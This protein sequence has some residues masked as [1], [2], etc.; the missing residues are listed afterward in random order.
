MLE[1]KDIEITTQSGETRNYVISKFPAIAGREIIAKYP[2][3]AI[4]RLGDYDVNEETMLKLMSYVGVRAGDQIVNLKTKALV[5]NHVPDWETLAHLE[6]EMINYNCSFFENGRASTFFEGIA[7]T[8]QA[9][10]LEM[11]TD[12]SEQSSRKE[13]PASES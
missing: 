2:I 9:K 7:Q 13:K 5:D 4:P 3:S 10:I 12:L 6:L 1:P 11:L 8:F